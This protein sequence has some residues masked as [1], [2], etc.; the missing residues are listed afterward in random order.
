MRNTLPF[1]VF[2]F[3]CFSVQSQNGKL[4]SLDNLLQHYKIKDT[5]RFRFLV[6][7]SE[8]ATMTDPEQG[9]SYA[10][11]AKAIGDDLGDDFLIGKALIWVAGS[12]YFKNDLP[13]ALGIYQEALTHAAKLKDPKLKFQIEQNLAN[14]YADLGDY[15]RAEPIYMRYLEYAISKKDVQDEVITR[16]NLGVLN[17]EMGET[18]KCIVQFEK[19]MQ[20]AQDY[21][22]QVYSAV[23]ANNLGD[24]YADLGKDQ[25]A[26]TFYSR[27]LQWAKMYGLDQI[28]LN[29]YHG[30]AKIDLK[31]G[32]LNEAEENASMALDMAEEAHVPLMQSKAWLTLSEIY[33]QQGSPKSLEAYKNHISLRDSVVA[34]EKKVAIAREEMQY[35]MEN[36]QQWADEELV[37]QKK[38]K[39][40]AIIS[41]SLILLLA[42]FSIWQYKRKRD[43][44]E[45]KKTSDLEAKLAESKL[46]ALR[47]QISPHFIFNSLNAVRYYISEK[48]IDTADEYLMTFASL[49]RSVLKNS[50]K[51]FIPLKE[52]LDILKLY[53]E[54]EKKRM[55]QGFKYEIQVCGD[56]D[57]ESVL[58]PPL[59]IQPFIK[60]CIW[61]RLSVLPPGQGILKVQILR[62]PAHLLVTIE[63]NGTTE[64]IEIPV[65]T[66]EK[67]GIDLAVQRL[68]ILNKKQGATINGNIKI[69]E[70]GSDSGIRICLPLQ[71][72]QL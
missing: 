45:G 32:Q 68:E 24:A 41:G 56:I 54:A 58:V 1:F 19:A 12:Y 4:D 46:R 15:E 70:N 29:I 53:I 31:N 62:K 69:F 7:A 5:L 57:Q 35:K 21:D 3:L 26:R 59:V 61:D 22:Y 48:H 9:L 51:E 52:E 67:S 8:I 23:I 55:A 47:A 25:Q 72:S 20:L 42:G 40:I 64:K 18:Q 66:M 65:N 2:L 11:E 10:L 30:L 14:V 71:T 27:A 28:T 63:D 36:L 50:E 49:I 38:I 13:R 16:V 33:E 39:N 34:E 44:L 37:F 60:H 43:A 17:M 6:Q